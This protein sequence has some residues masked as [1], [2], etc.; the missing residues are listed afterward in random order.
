LSPE[1]T[2]YTTDIYVHNAKTDEEDGETS[3][4]ARQHQRREGGMDEGKGK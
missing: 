4:S 1:R 2:S 3:F